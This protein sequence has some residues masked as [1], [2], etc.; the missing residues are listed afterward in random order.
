MQNQP[1]KLKVQEMLQVCQ[2]EI[3]RTT[4]IGKKMLSAS[5]TNTVL[6]EA[7]EEL[8]MLAVKELQDKK[9]QW[10]NPRVA[11]ILEQVKKCEKDLSSIESEM[12]K[13]KFQSGSNDVSK[14][15]K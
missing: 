13:I 11:E 5:K 10:D 9:L 15:K 14:D 12:N 4:E 7:Y 2:D 6:H 1:W 3:K 8:G